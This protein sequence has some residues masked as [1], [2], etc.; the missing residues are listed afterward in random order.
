M[1]Q[2]DST[3]D[4]DDTRARFTLVPHSSWSKR[5]KMVVFRVLGDKASTLVDVLP[6][7]LQDL[8][9]EFTLHLMQGQ[10]KDRAPLIRRLASVEGSPRLN[11]PSSYGLAGCMLC[12]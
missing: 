10:D 6:P 4:W 3:Y 9:L 2:G 1:G 7:N 12:W 8:Q 11:T 5:R